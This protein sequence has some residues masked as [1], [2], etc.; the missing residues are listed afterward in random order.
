MSKK[1][2][3]VLPTDREVAQYGG[4]SASADESGPPPP[5]QEAAA[6]QPTEQDEGA[7]TGPQATDKPRAEAEEWKEKFLRAKADLAN[8]QRRAEKDRGQTLRYANARL[9]QALLPILDDLERVVTS[10]SEQAGEVETVINGVKLTLENFLKVLRD[11]NV[12]RIEAAGKPFDPA[13]HEAMMQQPGEGD[14]SEPTVL[15][16]VVKGY[17]LYDRVLRPARVIVSK[18]AEAATE[19]GPEEAASEP[20]SEKPDE[21]CRQ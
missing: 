2:K 5:A 6:A 14:H 21:N 12:S 19:A 7:P 4:Q 10:E 3:V 17:Q 1:K 13:V 8:Y 18:P 9:V 20:T 15:Q 11:F 16:E